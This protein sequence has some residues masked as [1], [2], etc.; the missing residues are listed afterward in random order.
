ML[1]AG[2]VPDDFGRGITVPIPKKKKIGSLCSNDFRTITI[3]PIAS[4]IFECG[5]MAEIEMYLSSDKLQFG[6][7]KSIGCSNAIY[8]LKKTVEF[9]TA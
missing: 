3:N 6:F 5:L 9:L 7:K 4:K 1:Y 8:V 2:C